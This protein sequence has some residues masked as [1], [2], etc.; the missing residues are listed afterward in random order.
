MCIRDSSDTVFDTD[1]LN[2]RRMYGRR[3]ALNTTPSPSASSIVAQQSAQPSMIGPYIIITETSQVLVSMEKL[4]PSSSPS[5]PENIETEM[6][7]NQSNSPFAGISRN[8]RKMDENQMSIE[9]SSPPEDFMTI[10]RADI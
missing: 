6:N 7:D 3:H 10:D 9:P 5:N 8:P 1:P 2:F 4:F